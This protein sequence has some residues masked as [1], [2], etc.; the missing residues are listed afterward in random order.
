[1]S[2]KI[3]GGGLSALNKEIIKT[4]CQDPNDLLEAE[5]CE[6]LF[7]KHV[8]LH[9]A[10]LKVEEP[11]VVSF[12]EILA[13][14][15][16]QKCGPAVTEI[17]KQHLFIFFRA[18]ELSEKLPDPIIERERLSSEEMKKLIDRVSKN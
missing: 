4:S 17:F 12:M 9:I 13:K 11:E 5:R 2:A 16:S 8:A 3:H 10:R 6:A 1:M 14:S 18:I 7:Q 15:F